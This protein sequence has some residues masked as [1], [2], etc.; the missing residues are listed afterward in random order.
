MTNVIDEV[1][2]TLDGTS[3]AEV[4]KPVAQPNQ[5]VNNGESANGEPS[6]PQV[7][8][9][10]TPPAPDANTQPPTVP[11]VDD[12]RMWTVDDL[13]KQQIEEQSQE[14]LK[15]REEA[16]LKDLSPTPEEIKSEAE[17]KVAETNK[18][19]PQKKD[20]GDEPSQ[21]FEKQLQEIKTHADSKIS[22]AQDAQFKAETLLQQKTKQHDVEKQLLEERIAKL[23]E[24]KIALQQ[25]SL[26]RDDEALVTYSYLRNNYK[27][28][29]DDP[30]WAQKLGKFHLNFAS[31]YY[32]VPQEALNEM[33]GSYH[34]RQKRQKDAMAW[35]Y[36]RSWW[37]GVWTDTYYNDAPI[38]EPAPIRDLL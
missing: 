7:T 26:P 31:N 13:L 9:P 1:I 19:T 38:G 36:S 29:K 32:N 34:N 21:G 30:K 18:P 33:I 17:P 27:E 3:I 12:A 14:Q 15:A 4:A 16:I 20:K 35:W 11:E 6:Q 22:N 24:E 8:P 23:S 37:G 25:E 10:T 5:V 2:P 28:N